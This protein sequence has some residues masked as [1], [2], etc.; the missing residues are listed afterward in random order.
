M[1]PNNGEILAEASYPNYNLNKPRDLSAY[2]TKNELA[3]MTDK[4]ED[5]DT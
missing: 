3:K 5:R 4:R 1:N 2:Y